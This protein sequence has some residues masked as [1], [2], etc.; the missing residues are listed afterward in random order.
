MNSIFMKLYYNNDCDFI[1][2]LPNFLSKNNVNRRAD[3][4]KNVNSDFKEN[5]KEWLIKK[6][7]TNNITESKYPCQKGRLLL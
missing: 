6:Q 4:L 5:F 2:S 7:K 3:M 1:I